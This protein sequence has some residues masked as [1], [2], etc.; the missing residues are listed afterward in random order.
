[1][2]G[3][4]RASYLFLNCFIAAVQV[5]HVCFEPVRVYGLKGKILRSSEAGGELVNACNFEIP[6]HLIL[7]Y[8]ESDP[9]LPTIKKIPYM[10]NIPPTRKEGKFELSHAY[11]VYE[12]RSP[13]QMVNPLPPDLVVGI[14]ES[15]YTGMREIPV[16][17]LG[18]TR[19][20]N[21]STEEI[22]TISRLVND[23][24]REVRND[25]CE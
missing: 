15:C 1:V 25:G 4:R 6:P 16:R 20:L 9:I 10:C 23:Y 13:P 19:D 12:K 7:D 22:N 3:S 11:V 18:Q 2:P 5:K 21:L 14:Y 24:A 8:L 17:L